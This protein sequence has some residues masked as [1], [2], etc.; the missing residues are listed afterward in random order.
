MEYEG[1][2]PQD[3]SFNY[4]PY[5]FDSNFEKQAILRLLTEED[6]KDNNVELYY[7][8]MTD[9]DLNSFDIRTPHGRYTPDFLLLRR[10][11]NRPYDKN[12]EKQARIARVF[13]I[14]TKGK[15]FYDDEFKAKENFVKQIFVKRNPHIHYMNFVDEDNS[16]NFE[17]HMDTFRGTLS[18]WLEKPL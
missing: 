6:L 5:Q 14:E 12:K 17:T 10:Q 9:P 18:R 2:D 8:G 7:N 3:I 1:C 4:A 15:P 13:I 11:G 16:G